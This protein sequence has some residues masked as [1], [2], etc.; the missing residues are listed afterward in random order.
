V[1]PFA[2][3][4]LLFFIAY[5]PRIKLSS[6]AKKGDLSYGMYLYAWPIQQLLAYA[7]YKHIG[8]LTLFCL[9]VPLTYLAALMSWH[10]VEKIFLRFKTPTAERPPI[11]VPQAE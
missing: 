5:H 4:Y 8:P 3:A 11:T 6:F 10:Y 2:G 1:L 9:S 7:L